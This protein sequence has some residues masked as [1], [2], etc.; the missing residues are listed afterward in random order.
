M[1]VLNVYGLTHKH[2]NNTSVSVMVILNQFSNLRQI[3][4]DLHF[5]RSQQ[6]SYLVWNILN[7]NSIII[8][9]V[10]RRSMCM[11]LQHSLVRIQNSNSMIANLIA[12]LVRDLLSDMYA[13]CGHMPMAC[14]WL[15]HDKHVQMLE[16]CL[17]PFNIWLIAI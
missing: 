12:T 6:H 3:T 11:S 8:H 17:W 15:S 7:S 4:V 14:C 5:P 2:I 1:T 9:I 13:E 16:E 10:A